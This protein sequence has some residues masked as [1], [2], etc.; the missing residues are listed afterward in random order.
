MTRPRTRLI[1]AADADR[2]R[3]AE[4]TARPL[5]W[6]DESAEAATLIRRTQAPLKIVRL[7]FTQEYPEWRELQ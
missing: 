3:L 4:L 5:L 7:N 6:A 1:D 2:T